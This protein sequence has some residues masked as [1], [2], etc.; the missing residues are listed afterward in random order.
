MS[1]TENKFD[2]EKQ[3]TPFV[4]SPFYLLLRDKFLDNKLLSVSDNLNKKGYAIVDLN[5]PNEIIDTANNDIENAILQNSYKKN[6][7]TYHYNE[8]PRIVEA[9]KFSNSIRQILSNTYLLEILKFC[10]QSNPIPISTINFLKGSEQPFHSDEFHYGSLPHRYLTGVW[11]ALEDINP[12]SGPLSLVEGSHKFPIFSLEQIGIKNP[13]NEKQQKEIY[14]VYEEWAAE[15][16][17][18]HKLKIVTPNVKKGECII[19]LSNTLHGAYKINDLSLS[20][21]SIAIH[22][23]Y[24]KCEKIFYPS[25]SNLEKGRY[26]QRSIADLDIR[27]QL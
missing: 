5:I 9:W 24:E 21:K 26:I 18:A 8:S 7:E 16:I 27:N 23:H 4:E 19:W 2:I 25:F 3:R 11:V 1:E 14:T 15:M 17:K 6:A 22:Y 12:D 20:R 10:Y 13:K